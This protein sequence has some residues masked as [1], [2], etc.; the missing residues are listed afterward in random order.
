MRCSA[1]GAGNMQIFDGIDDDDDDDD[2]ENDGAEAEDDNVED[3][4]LMYVRGR[5][6]SVGC[7]TSS[8]VLV[9]VS[10]P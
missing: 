5:L 8:P 4:S 6:L 2:D 3:T 9:P 1:A 7:I 10:I